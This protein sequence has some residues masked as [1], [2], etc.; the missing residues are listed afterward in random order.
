MASG[1]DGAARGPDVAAAPGI[2]ARGVG[3]GALTVKRGAAARVGVHATLV[4]LLLTSAACTSGPASRQEPGPSGPAAPASAG[5]ESGSPAASNKDA[6]LPHS[7]KAER[8]LPRQRNG[9][10]ESSDAATPSA[11]PH[12]T[13]SLRAEIQARAEATSHGPIGNLA[14]E[15]ASLRLA[16]TSL[17]LIDAGSLGGAL[18]TLER[19]ISLW[20]KNGY[21]YTFLAYVQ[22]A[23]GRS[24]RAA[25][26]LATAGRY[27]PRDRAVR[28]EFEAL[29]AS[30]RHSTPATGT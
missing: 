30:V 5:I 17:D 3:A 18:E 6:E 14:V 29:D 26:Y 15:L 20:G 4:A 2:R 1:T 24:D 27:L 21:A 16:A 11:F 10:A 25:E 7:R 13:A 28:G 23:Q 12:T 8:A 19:S 22:Q 9:V